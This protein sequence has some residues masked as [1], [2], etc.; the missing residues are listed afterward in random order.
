MIEGPPSALPAPPRRRHPVLVAVL[1]VLGVL[2]LAA[3]L[4]GFVIHLPYVIISPG[5]ATPLDNRIVVIHGADTD[6]HPHRGSFRFLTVT[7]STHDPNLWR[8]LSAWLDSDQDIEDRTSVVGCLN[9]ADNFT[10]NTELMQQSQ[11]TARSV[12]LTR[13]G[14]SVH[15][16]TP[17][18]R[19]VEVCPGV[20]AYGMLHTGDTVRAVDGRAVENRSAVAALV[21]AHHPGD[22]IDV[23]F[24]HD[25]ASRHARITAGRITVGGTKCVPAGHETSGTACLGV[26]SFDLVSYQFPIDVSINTQRVSGPSAGLA[27]ALAIIDDLTPGDLTGG[28]EVAVTG[29][30]EPDGSVGAV[31]GVEQK[32]ITARTNHVALMIVPTAEVADARRGAGNVPVVGVATLE[33][34]LGALRNAGGAEVPPPSS[35]VVRS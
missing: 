18:V 35:T 15:A 5:S 8:L 10:Y 9:D 14:Y 2:V 32:A 29:T 20:P 22:P 11:N 33:D 19:V 27:F 13:L 6:A 26:A 1:S 23:T 7:V 12:A 25:G 3:T 30:I 28:K 24:D 21:R 17:T 31:G 16:D 34:A 4:A